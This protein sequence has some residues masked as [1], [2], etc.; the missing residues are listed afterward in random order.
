MP[1]TDDCGAKITSKTLEPA[2]N[3]NRDI[4]FKNPFRRALEGDVHNA[5]SI[6]FFNFEIN[7]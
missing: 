3:S 2:K 6:P 4:A 7:T 5:E 1:H